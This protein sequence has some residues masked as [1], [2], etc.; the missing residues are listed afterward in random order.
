MLAEQQELQGVVCYP[1]SP[2]F[3]PGVHFTSQNGP[4]SSVFLRCLSDTKLSCLASI[5]TVLTAEYLNQLSSRRDDYLI[6]LR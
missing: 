6:T 3:L 5:F 4:D 2:G 1:G